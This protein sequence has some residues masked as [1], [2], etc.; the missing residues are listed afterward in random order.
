[1]RFPRSDGSGTYYISEI[2]QC[3]GCS[4]VFADPESFMR[5]AKRLDE[6]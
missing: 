6:T 2:W 3:G 1:V 4:V 5:N